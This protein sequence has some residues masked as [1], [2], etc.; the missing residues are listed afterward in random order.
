MRHELRSARRAGVL[1]WPARTQEPPRLS[2]AESRPEGGLANRPWC[3]R[4]SRPLDRPSGVGAQEDRQTSRLLAEWLSVQTQPDVQDDD[5]DEAGEQEGPDLYRQA[6]VVGRSSLITHTAQPADGGQA[7]ATPL[8]PTNRPYRS[9]GARRAPSTLTGRSPGIQ[10]R[11]HRLDS[12][13]EFWQVDRDRVPHDLVIHDVVTMGEDVA[14]SR[15]C[16]RCPGCVRRVPVPR[17]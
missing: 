1:P 15:R 17:G 12:R 13:G 2:A 16:A 8:D 9:G 7:G 10:L 11:E 4:L 6:T 3:T 14:E 5:D